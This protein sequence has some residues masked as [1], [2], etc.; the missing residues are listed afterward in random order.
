MKDFKDLIL[1]K[2][3]NEVRILN[4]CLSILIQNGQLLNKDLDLLCNGDE[5][6]SKRLKYCLIET[7][8]AK[9]N[10]NFTIRILLSDKT[11]K[12]LETDYYTL[13]YKE[14]VEKEKRERLELTKLKEE[15]ELTKKQSRF[16]VPAFKVS[17]ISIILS[18]VSSILQLCLS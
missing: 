6:L 10:P 7:G 14:K 12:Y 9:E 4:Q 5:T 3:E 16:A 17:V 2:S 11:K 18:L 1:P 8:A 13:I 15:I